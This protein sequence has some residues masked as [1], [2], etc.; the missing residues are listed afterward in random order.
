MVKE[1]RIQ[2]KMTIF[3]GVHDPARIYLPGDMVTRGGS[4]WHCDTE[5]K[6]PFN[7]DYWTLS[8]KKGRDG[9]E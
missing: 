2:T 7:G 1:S 3:R 6:G 9:K 5:C 8:A 4:V